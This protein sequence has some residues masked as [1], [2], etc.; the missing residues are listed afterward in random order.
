MN[1]EQQLVLLG[2]KDKEARAYTALLKLYEANP[3]E[4]A[5]EARLERTGIYRV[6]D[7][8]CESGLIERT[9]KGKR[10][11]YVAK[12]PEAIGK[13]LASREEVFA[14]L[15]PLLN[16][17]RG[18]KGEKTVVKYYEKKEDIKRAYNESLN[19]REKLRRDFVLSWTIYDVL[20]IQCLQR[21]LDVRVKNKVQVRSIRRYPEPENIKKNWQISSLEKEKV[22]REIRYIEGDIKFKPVVLIYDHV[23]QIYST[24][25]EGAVL[26]IENPDLAEAMKTLFDFT[27]SIAKPKSAIEKK[28]KKK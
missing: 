4:I 23:V 3:Q 28:A 27:W 11:S 18:S 2:L 1:I 13:L 10:S 19:A 5:K 24:P 15:L 9:I 20:G 14:G 12:S 22:M 6:L 25:K 17:F 7:G 26:V 21:G 16:A 8:L